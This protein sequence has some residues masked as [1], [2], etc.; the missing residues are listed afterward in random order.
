MS[1][2]EKKVRKPGQFGNLLELSAINYLEAETKTGR[3]SSDKYSLR[4]I[5]KGPESDRLFPTLPSLV[6]VRDVKVIDGMAV[7]D[8]S[9]EVLTETSQIPQSSTSE[10]LAIFSIVNTITEFEEIERFKITIESME[11]GARKGYPGFLGTWG[12]YDVF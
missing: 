7:V 6:E 1:T 12:I 11:S 2:G 3:N 10:T 4:E 9:S 8:F 5:V